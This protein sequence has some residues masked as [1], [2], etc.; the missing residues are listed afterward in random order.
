MN[1]T[2]TNPPTVPPRLLIVEDD[3]SI[4]L[5]IQHWISQHSGRLS[6]QHVLT[7]EDAVLAVPGAACVILDLNLA[8]E[9]RMERTPRII[10]ELR[11][12]APV[13]ALTG[14]SEGSF[15]ADLDFAG[16]LVSHYGADA[17]VFKDMMMTQ[18]GVNWLFTMVH[19]AIAR[20]LYDATI[21]P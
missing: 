11:K 4:P 17:V 8:P 18:N 7:V 12:H 16:S 19:A 3:K 9:W 6:V 14:Y 21:K 20:R 2:R 1:E 15:E 5:L 10:P 13:I